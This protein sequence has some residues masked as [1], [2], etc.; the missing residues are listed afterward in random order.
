MREGAMRLH[1]SPEI[2]WIDDG[3]PELRLVRERG[4]FDLVLM[5]AVFMHL[6]A[7][8]RA[9]AMPNVVCCW[10][11]RRADHDIAARADAVGRRMFDVTGEET[12]ELARGLELLMHEKRASLRRDVRDASISW[13][14]LAFRKP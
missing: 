11:G 12:I 1:P 8:Q 7:A 9:E 3:L 13:T 6:D 5:T 2:E 10:R 14:Q 4:P